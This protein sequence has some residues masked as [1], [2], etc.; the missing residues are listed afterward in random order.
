MQKLAEIALKESEE[1][2]RT[3]FENIQDVFFQTNMSGIIIEISPSIKYHSQFTREELIGTEV[4]KMYYYPEERQNFLKSL[5]INGEIHNFELRLK[6]KTSELRYVSIN[7]LI[8]T[9]ANGN[10]VSISGSYRD[11]TEKKKADEVLKVSE[12]RFRIILE[13]MPILLNAFDEDGNVIVWNKA[14]EE[15]TGYLADEIIG[16]PKAMELLYPNPEYRE[17][18]MKS[19]ANPDSKNKDFDLMT[20][21]GKLRT[22]FWFDTYHYLRVPGWDSWGMGLDITDRKLAEIALK[23]SEY[24]FKT[25]ASKAS[26]G[27]MIHRNGIILDANM[28][29]ANMLGFNN[30][31]VLIGKNAFEI[32]KLTPE[33]K[34]FILDHSLMGSED[35]YDIEIF[36]LKGELLAAETKGIKIQYKGS[37]A[38]L[39]YMHDLSER[40]KAE[41]T[42]SMLAH[43]IRS[44]GECVS[45]T[46]MDDKILFVNRAFLN[47]YQYDEHELLGNSVSIVRSP[48]NAPEVVEQI[49]K[50][51]QLG[52]WNGEILNRRKDGSEFP[53]Y[54]STSVIS[55]EYGKPIALIGVATDITER[56]LVEQAL[57]KSE[58]KYRAFF[59]NITEVFYQ[60][61]LEGIILEVSPSIL[62]Y[63]GYSR[64]ELIGTSIS[65]FYVNPDDRIFLINEVMKNGEIKDYETRFKNKNGDIV[66]A[67]INTR[68]IFDS[69]GR[70]NHLLG[71]IR[72]VT[73]KKRA[74]EL[75]E[76]Q[77]NNSPD[78]ILIIDR[79]FKVELVNRGI[80]GVHTIESTLG[81]NYLSLLPK[82]FQN[83]ARKR[84]TLCLET[85]KTCSFPAAFRYGRYFATRMVPIADESGEVSKVMIIATDITSQV[86]SENARLQSNEKY[87]MVSKASH[88]DIWDLNVLTGKITRSTAE[89]NSLFEN[90]SG[91]KFRE[92]LN[93][94][95]LVHPEDFLQLKKSLDQ[96]FNDPKEHFWEYTY[97]FQKSGGAYAYVHDR[98]YIVRDRLG[99]AK[100]IIGSTRDI[101]ERVLHQKAIEEQN[102]KLKEIAWIQSH[103]VRAP[104]SRMMGIVNLLKE[105]EITSDEFK[106]WTGHFDTSATELDTIIR[107]ISAKSRQL[108]IDL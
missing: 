75:F 70:P 98:A 101:T 99:K 40:K 11:I 57:I 67:A 39:V 32:I 87:K 17:D 91:K 43:A 20:K 106:E 54:I 73:E 83:T 69:E 8:N 74:T 61:S 16:N 13:N 86:K 105:M 28:A 65:R 59:E 3:I 51:T 84:I 77:F 10:P 102:L 45:I 21:D 100:R 12:E 49:L 31:D 107:E 48:N 108:G 30:P 5:M 24:R 89:F 19:S 41:K 22:I 94:S 47:T 35:L 60:T 72:D 7:A 97:R 34:Q 104:L 29:F 53:V 27:L 15:A 96:A 25:L 1:K 85:N 44:I 46:D 90:K 9:D 58:E 76:S 55:D 80:P 92:N 33:S 23:E 62:K 52:G 37:E 78:N 56:K 26:E 36:N 63:S 38:R 95:N 50:A 18:I 6:A 79:N 81:K 66:I 4:A 71:L 64:E 82:H 68:L 103:V 42:I 14:C 2:Y 88:D 93:L